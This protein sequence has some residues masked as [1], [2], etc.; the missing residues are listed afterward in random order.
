MVKVEIIYTVKWFIINEFRGVK[1]FKGI[2]HFH[3]NFHNR[4]QV[5]SR[6]SII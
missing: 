1:R 2:C 4:F 5:R 6:L 3:E